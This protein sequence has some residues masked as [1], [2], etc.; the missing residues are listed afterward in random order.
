MGNP[1]TCIHCLEMNWRMPTGIRTTHVIT[2][3]QNK[4]KNYNR[5]VD[6]YCQLFTIEQNYFTKAVFIKL[7]LNNK[8]N[9]NEVSKWKISYVYYVITKNRN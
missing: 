2:K 9:L 6:W 1:R 3:M 5:R 4:K 8:K 7:M